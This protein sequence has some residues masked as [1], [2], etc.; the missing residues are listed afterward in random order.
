MQSLVLIEPWYKMF[1]QVRTQQSHTDADKK[2]N[3]KVEVGW[4]RSFS[5]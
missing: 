5:N 1:G 4:F 2:K 3:L